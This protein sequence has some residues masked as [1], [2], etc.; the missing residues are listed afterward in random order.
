[1][2]L[3]YL[4]KKVLTNK[5]LPINFNVFWCLFSGA[6]QGYFGKPKS[7]A[8]SV[9]S[10][11]STSIHLYP[12]NKIGFVLLLL[13]WIYL[14]I[15]EYKIKIKLTVRAGNFLSPKFGN[16]WTFSYLIIQTHFPKFCPGK[17][18][19]FYIPQMSPQKSAVLDFLILSDYETPFCSQNFMMYIYNSFLFVEIRPALSL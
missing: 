19:A 2:G 4:H 12:L 14:S 6:Q 8:I 3:C 10:S 16:H 1:M 18:D 17:E 5:I 7:Q 13:V 9:V 15:A 11:T